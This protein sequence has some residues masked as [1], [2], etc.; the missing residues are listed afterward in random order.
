M[1]VNSITVENQES[2]LRVNVNYTLRRTQQ[3]QTAQFERQV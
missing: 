2:T 3:N 1:Q